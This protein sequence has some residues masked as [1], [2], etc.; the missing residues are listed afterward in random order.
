MNV[1]VLS[2]TDTD[3]P[4]A[5]AMGFR[6]LL[7]QRVTVERTGQKLRVPTYSLEIVGL[8]GKDELAKMVRT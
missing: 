4:G 8:V 5:I 2:V 7:H 6:L 1:S 3:L